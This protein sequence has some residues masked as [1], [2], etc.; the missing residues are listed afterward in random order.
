MKKTVIIILIVLLGLVAGIEVY[1]Q[2]DAFALKLRPLV[3]EPLKELL[4][5]DATI[6]LV[7]AHFFPPYLEVRDISIPDAGGNEAIAIRRIRAYLNPLPLLLKKIRL[8]SIS[9]LEPRIYVERAKDGTINLSPL[10]GRIKTNMAHKESE[11]ASGYHLLLSHL[12]LT[13]GR[14]EYKDGRTSLHLSM[15]DFNMTVNVDSSQERFT[16]RIGKSRYHVSE[17]SYP[18]ISGN[19]RATAVYDRGRTHLD[20]G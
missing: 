16:T 15:S 19:F 1:V 13:K 5:E 11:G 18:E 12:S 17:P 8:P 2:S 9:I 4:G 14:I 10:F 6:G 20:A 3:I 7:K